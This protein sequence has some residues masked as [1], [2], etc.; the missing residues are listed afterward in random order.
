[1]VRVAIVDDTRLCREGL[2]HILTREEHV[3]VAGMAGRLDES[4]ALVRDLRPD[5]ILLRMATS[6]S[7]LILRAIVE[8]TPMAKVVV[9]GVS[10]GED[11]V[12]ACAEAGAAG[13]LL[14]DGSVADLVAAIQ[15]VAS[16]ETLCSPRIA[17]T[18]L[19]R[20]AVLAAER[21]SL[22]T[23]AHLTRRETEIVE[24]IDQGLSN[25]EIAR[26]LTI[27]VRTVKNHVHNVLEKLQVHRRGEAAA[28]IRKGPTR[29]LERTHPQI[30]QRGTSPF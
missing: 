26:R 25:K 18:L 4:L 24:L 8:V 5:V 29:A 10:E 2:A 12:V 23:L 3:S 28:R 13:Y 11:E 7:L 20:V 30:P 16:G 17:A 1:M 27:E 22:A 21:Q 6:E 14:R 19:R 15:S 9:L